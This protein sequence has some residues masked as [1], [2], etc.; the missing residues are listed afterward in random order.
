MFKDFLYFLLLLKDLG[1]R[2]WTQ[3]PDSSYW[4]VGS[5]LLG[6]NI[7]LQVYIAFILHSISDPDPQYKAFDILTLDSW[8]T[9]LNP[10]ISVPV[11]KTI[12]E[13]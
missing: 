11:G 6:N 5:E 2:V 9:E 4:K 1:W 8:V 10:E 13:S 7:V 3:D 12:L